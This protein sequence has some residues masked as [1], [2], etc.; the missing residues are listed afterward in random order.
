MGMTRTR[1]TVFAIRIRFSIVFGGLKICGT[2]LLRQAWNGL[3]SSV[4]RTTGS[5]LDISSEANASGV[6]R[7][8]KKAHP[9]VWLDVNT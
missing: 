1:M 9:H 4:S 8:E 5:T 7:R 6:S 2:V 3:G